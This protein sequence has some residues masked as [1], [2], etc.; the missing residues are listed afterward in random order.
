M[1]SGAS[2]TRSRS[3]RG[4]APTRGPLAVKGTHVERPFDR[5]RQPAHH[6]RPSPATAG[7]LA[8][9]LPRTDADEG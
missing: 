6:R 3:R 8:R 1:S 5:D 4:Q 9:G 7:V 2:A